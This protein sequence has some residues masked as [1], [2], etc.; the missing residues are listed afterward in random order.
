[1]IRYADWV[2]RGL[3]VFFVAACVAFTWAVLLP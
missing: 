1:M 2:V 3:I